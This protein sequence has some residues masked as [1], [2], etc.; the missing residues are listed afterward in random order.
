MHE[1]VSL[2]RKGVI[3]RW[4]NYR[5]TI[6]TGADML[7]ILPLPCIATI[8]TVSW[9]TV[10]NTTVTRTKQNTMFANAIFMWRRLKFTPVFQISSFGVDEK[11]GSYVELARLLH[12]EIIVCV[13]CAALY[14]PIPTIEMI[15]F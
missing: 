5:S 8:V 11:S 13:I 15:S 7:T 3:L 9:R 1:T 6:R 4:M 14:N 12:N 10:V 2:L